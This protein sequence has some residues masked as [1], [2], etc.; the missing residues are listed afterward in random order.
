MEDQQIPAQEAGD[1][2]VSE[3]DAHTA[4]TE[5]EKPEPKRAEGAQSDDGDK[6]GDE[7]SGE[8]Q[9]SPAKARRERRKAEMERLRT[10]AEEARREDERLRR[11]LEQSG[12]DAD[13]A[14]KREDFQDYEE[15]QAALAAHKVMSQLSAKERA[16]LEGQSK[17]SEAALKALSQRERQV[18]AQQW[19][20]QEAEAKARY[21]DYE[22]VAR[23]P[24]LPITEA[25]VHVM[26]QSEMGP[27][28]AYHLGSNPAVAA[29]IARMQPLE[30]ARE[31]GRIEARL[32]LPKAPT[33]TQAPDPVSPV[34]PK[35]RAAKDPANM[36]MDE[37]IAARK[38]GLIR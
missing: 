11:Q 21:A 6:D 14:P 1:E 28:L 25:M 31:M 36:S 38:S 37:W 32:S 3:T 10:E 33:Q 12:G 27:D 22:A 29:R 5:A 9:I 4:D 18:L 2:V 7:G 23:N 15:W 17:E 24:D 35:A 30:M 19:A 34:K 16:K 20:D 13:P 26:L 8:E